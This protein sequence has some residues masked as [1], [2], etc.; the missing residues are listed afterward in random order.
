MLPIKRD[1]VAVSQSPI[2]TH[3]VR[4]PAVK[5][6]RSF[7][8]VRGESLAAQLGNIALHVVLLVVW[9]LA[10]GANAYYLLFQN[11]M[12]FGTCP[13]GF[14]HEVK[15]GIGLALAIP[16][17]LAGGYLFCY[18]ER[19]VEMIQIAFPDIDW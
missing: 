18:F 9:V 19:V 10:I 5:R 8:V 2:V 11:E 12:W 7:A 1:P 6:F 13:P 17:S 16:L 14:W 3:F 15:H 4:I